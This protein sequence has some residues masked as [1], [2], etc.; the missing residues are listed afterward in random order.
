VFSQ[1]LGAARRSCCSAHLG[2][3]TGRWQP[4]PQRELSIPAG[5]GRGAGSSCTLAGQSVGPF[6]RGEPRQWLHCRHLSPRLRAPETQHLAGCNSSELRPTVWVQLSSLS[7]F[8]VPKAEVTP[9]PSWCLGLSGF[10]AACVRRSPSPRE[11]C[12]PFTR[13]LTL[14]FCFMLQNVFLSCVCC[15]R[16]NI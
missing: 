3:G 15:F 8:P 9:S 1:G 7:A 4:C 12:G 2:K 11:L 13:C 10:V 6:Q 16:K 14:V 5:M